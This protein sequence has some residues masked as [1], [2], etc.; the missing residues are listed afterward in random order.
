[1]K[2]LSLVFCLIFSAPSIAN[3]LNNTS[4][5][6]EF[7]QELVTL[8]ANEKF[9]EALNKSKKY[10]PLPEVEID[11]MANK[12]TMQWPVIQQ[13]FGK[14]IGTELVKEQRIGNSFHRYYFLHKFENHAIYWRFDF[15]KAKENWKINRIVF[16]DDLDTLYE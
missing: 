2:Y 5:T 11:N 14:A 8:F 6:R 15:Y 10:W 13:R 7:A 1:M 16:K 9:S 4:E 12:I 3:T